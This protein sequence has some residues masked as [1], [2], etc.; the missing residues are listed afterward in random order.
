MLRGIHKAT[1]TW[2]GKA[3]MAVVFAISYATAWVIQ[4]F[5]GGIRTDYAA[6]E[7]IPLPGGEAAV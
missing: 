1:S 5:A 2:V 4:A 3:V 6:S 7:L